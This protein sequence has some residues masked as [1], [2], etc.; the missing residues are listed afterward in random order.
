MLEEV[1]LIVVKA[2]LVKSEVRNQIQF[3]N[4]TYSAFI[5]LFGVFVS[6]HDCAFGY[7]VKCKSII[8]RHTKEGGLH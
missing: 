4:S 8:F 1:V 2:S 7:N 6:T 3:L 5:H